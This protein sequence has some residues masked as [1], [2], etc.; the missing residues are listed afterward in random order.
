M[1]ID[2]E[3]T[4]RFGVWK[5]LRCSDPWTSKHDTNWRL[6][7]FVKAHNSFQFL[8]NALSDAKFSVSDGEIAIVFDAK[9]ALIGGG[10]AIDAM[11]Y[12]ARLFLND[13][14]EY[15]ENHFSESAVQYPKPSESF[16]TLFSYLRVYDAQITDAKNNQIAAVL[17][18]DIPEL[19]GKDEY[20][21]DLLRDRAKNV[22]SRVNKLSLPAKKYVCGGYAAFVIYP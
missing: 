5:I 4:R 8:P 6:N 10:Q 2:P 7:S 17:F 19:I 14:L 11:L 22:S 20:D 9:Q 3:V 13:E 18:K 21:K 15:I 1:S 16:Q 12:K